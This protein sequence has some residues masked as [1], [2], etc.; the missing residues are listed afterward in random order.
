M[1]NMMSGYTLGYNIYHI[2]EFCKLI[3]EN[4]FNTRK[5][6]KIIGTLKGEI[7]LE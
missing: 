5:V 3:V 1:I 2:P 6:Y 4:N 7:Y